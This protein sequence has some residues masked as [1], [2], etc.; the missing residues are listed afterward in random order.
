MESPDGEEAIIRCGTTKGDITLK[1][2]REWS[3][4]GYDRAVELFERH[5]YDGSHFY[6]AVPK[7]LVQFG[8]SYSKDKELQSFARKQI[9]DDPK[10]NPPIE[11][12]PGI[13]S[14]AGSGPNSRGSQMFISYGSAKSLGRELWETPIGKVIEGMDAAEQFYS[15][16]DMP[17]WGKG[18]A[19][20]KIHS[21]PEYI[22]EGFPLIDKFLECTVKRSGSSE[23]GGKAAEMG[24]DD[25]DDMNE[26]AD[27]DTNSNEEAD[28]IEMVDIDDDTAEPPSDHGEK[29]KRRGIRSTVHSDKFY[30]VPQDVH[31][32]RM[33][34]NRL[35]GNID[36]DSYVF[37][38]GVILVMVL[39]YVLLRRRG[40]ESAKEN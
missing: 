40:K 27:D 2:I 25:G 13:I 38:V 24:G 34:F 37:P 30:A 8:I 1:L 12:H 32:K 14:Y 28:E 9:Q 20:G 10:H 23:I 15:Y 17:P 21:G 18:P 19:Q 31:E 39:L 11:F 7:F 5:F 6:R 33:R 29:Q 36:S 22:E 26:K 3:P 35:A 16:G 4:K